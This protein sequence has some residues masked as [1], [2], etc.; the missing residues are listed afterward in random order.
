MDLG[1][2]SMLF[3]QIGQEVLFNMLWALARG[4]MP[5][6][7]KRS[8]MALEP[9]VS[10]AQ[11]MALSIFHECPPHALRVPDYVPQAVHPVSSEPWVTLFGFLADEIL[12]VYP[13]T[14]AR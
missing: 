4:D 7:F 13:P 3:L 5:S 1:P 11:K 10:M 8:P 2:R 9:V 14:G 12:K 6:L